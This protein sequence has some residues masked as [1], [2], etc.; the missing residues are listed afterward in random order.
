MVQNA[1]LDEPARGPRSLTQFPQEHGPFTGKHGLEEI[2]AG[3]VPEVPG[4][5]IAR[6]DINSDAPD[7]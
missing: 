5:M 7:W 2:R 6:Y 1:N 3:S 4:A